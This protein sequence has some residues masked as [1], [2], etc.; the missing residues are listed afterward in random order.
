[1]NFQKHDD[2][3]G[4]DQQRVQA[5]F[6]ALVADP[7]YQFGHEARRVK[8]RGRF[9][10]DAELPAIFVESGDAVGT[11]LVVAPVPFIFPVKKPA[12]FNAG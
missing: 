7:R 1:M 6:V 8:G 4:N 2:K 10:H 5:R 3:N 11:C 12:A 9:E